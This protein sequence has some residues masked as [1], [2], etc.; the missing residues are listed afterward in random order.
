MT[1]FRSA[2]VDHLQWSIFVWNRIWNLFEMYIVKMM[3]LCKIKLI[4]RTDETEF[5]IYCDS[6]LE[7]S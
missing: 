7:I 3:Q 1:N 4:F 6:K 2:R 5:G